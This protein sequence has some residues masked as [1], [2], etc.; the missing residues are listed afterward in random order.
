[1]NNINRWVIPSSAVTQYLHFFKAH[2]LFKK[3]QK[4]I[5]SGLG[6]VGAPWVKIEKRR[7]AQKT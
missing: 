1:M 4:K 7:P 3:P 2:V 5:L 6:D